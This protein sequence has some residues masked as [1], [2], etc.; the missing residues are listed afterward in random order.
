M[1]VGVFL[2]LSLLWGAWLMEQDVEQKDVKISPTLKNVQKAN[3]CKSKQI[4]KHIPPQ[5]QT[6]TYYIRLFGGSFFF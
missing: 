4:T 5:I 3:R 6:Y 1:S 2:S